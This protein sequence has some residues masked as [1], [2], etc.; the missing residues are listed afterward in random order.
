MVLGEFIQSLW[1][2]N[3][4]SKEEEIDSINF[5]QGARYLEFQ[6]NKTE[7]MQNNLDL[8]SN[9]CGYSPNDGSCKC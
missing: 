8:I 9:S 5:P 7:R 3:E 4:V 2:S 1:E 6:L